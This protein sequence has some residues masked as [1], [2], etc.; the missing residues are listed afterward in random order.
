MKINYTQDVINIVDRVKTMFYSP[1]T[2]QHLQHSLP[3][4]VCQ[5]KRK[6]LKYVNDAQSWLQQKA[7][8]T[9]GISLPYS[10]LSS[11]CYI[12]LSPESERWLPRELFVSFYN[13]LSGKLLSDNLTK[14]PACQPD[15]WRSVACTPLKHCRAELTVFFLNLKCLTLHRLL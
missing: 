2:G 9:R 11:C 8:I 5:Q 12:T 6:V 4:R 15:L 13:N 10:E 1:I 3:I 14:W 7:Q